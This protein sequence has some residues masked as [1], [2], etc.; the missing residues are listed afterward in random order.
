M[1]NRGRTVI[2]TP[3]YNSQTPLVVPNQNNQ[4]Q[5]ST[6]FLFSR[7]KSSTVQYDRLEDA[8]REEKANLASTE[9]QVAQWLPSSAPWMVSTMFFALL[10]IYLAFIGS[11]YSV[12]SSFENGFS[13]DLCRI[14]FHTSSSNYR[15]AD[16]VGPHSGCPSPDINPAGPV[17]REP[18]FHSGR[19][20]VCS[21][22]SRKATLCWEAE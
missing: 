1:N 21:R 15:Y 10:S 16:T 13:T 9:P 19:R 22:T 11:S 18:V 14:D 20:R 6:M 2:A 8:S 5:Q 3:T 7:P 4:L 12:S 17:R